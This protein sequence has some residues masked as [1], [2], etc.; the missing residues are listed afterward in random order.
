MAILD[1]TIDDGGDPAVKGE[2]LTYTFF[3]TNTDPTLAAT[4][5]VISTTIPAGTTFNPATSNAGWSCPNTAAGT[6]CTLTVATLN[7][8]ASGS[9]TFT[10]N[11]DENAP[12]VPLDIFTT[13]TQSTLA[14]TQVVTLVAGQTNLTL[15]AG[16]VILGSSLTTP[17]PTDPT[18]IPGGEQ[19]N[20]RKSIFLPTVQ[21][22][23]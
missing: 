23:K 21:Y 15:D 20:Q 12:N 16:I 3:Y 18:N 6:V 10:V 4:N 13:V 17:T 22:Q 2:P 7:G 1:I 5:V 11:I 8:N 14:R 9:A 19:P